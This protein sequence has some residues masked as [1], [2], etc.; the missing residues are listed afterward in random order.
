MDNNLVEQIRQWD[1]DWSQRFPFRI[2][3]KQKR[4]FLHEI[5]RELTSRNF[6]TQQIKARNLLQNQILLT[7]CEQPKIIFLAHFDTPTIIPFWFNWLFKLFG[8]TRQM[9]ALIVLLGFI[10]MPTILP[11]LGV[12][13]GSAITIIFDVIRLVITVSF[14]TLFIP[15]PKNRED[16]TS[17]VIGLLAIAEWLSHHPDMQKHVQLAFLDNEEWGLLGSSALRQYWNKQQHPYT[18]AAIINLDCISR[19]QKP[20]IVHHKNDV[21]AQ[22]LL[23]FLQP[24]LPN[25]EVKDMKGMPLSDNYTFK[26]EGAIDISFFDPTIIPGGYYIPKIHTPSDNNFFPEKMLPLI[27]GLTSFILNQTIMK[28]ES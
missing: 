5:E 17:G 24:H 2:T 28:S 12:Q 22:Q 8:H 16:N 20:M 4:R 15:N 27:T 18:D 14:I 26:Q 10:Y 6:A 9:L 23:P 25:T 11:F 13:N 3:K 7:E 19:G 1:E 21:I